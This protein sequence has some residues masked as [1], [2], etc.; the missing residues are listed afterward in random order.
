MP[1]AIRYP[2]SSPTIMIMPPSSKWNPLLD[3]DGMPR[4]QSE[5]PSNSNAN[6]VQVTVTRA[7]GNTYGPVT[8][9]F[10]SVF[11]IGASTVSASAQ[12][13]MGYAASTYTGTVQVPIALPAIGTSQSADPKL[14]ARLRLVGQNIRP[15]RGRG[16]GPYYQD[17]C[18]AGIR[19]ATIH[20]WHSDP[21]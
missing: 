21:G 10:A 15:R 9:F 17:H 11:G 18:L 19:P 1:T 20:P 12:A 16:L 5:V 8:N 14:Q 2:S 4:D 7:A 6:A 13:Y 3:G